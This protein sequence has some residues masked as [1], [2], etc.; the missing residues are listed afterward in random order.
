M[1]GY[2]KALL[3]TLYHIHSLQYELL[4]STS[5]FR[6]VNLDID[7]SL[8]VKYLVAAIKLESREKETASILLVVIFL[9]TQT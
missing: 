1:F 6:I 4:A 2:Y 5:S 7:Q 3:K 8:N 9:S